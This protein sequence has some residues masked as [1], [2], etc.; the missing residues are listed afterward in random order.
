MG[1]GVGVNAFLGR[2]GSIVVIHKDHNTRFGAEICP[3]IW[4]VVTGGTD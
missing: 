2:W 1:V 4:P 3:V